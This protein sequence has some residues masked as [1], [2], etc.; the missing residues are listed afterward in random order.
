M[1]INHHKCNSWVGTEGY[2]D[3]TGKQRMEEGHSKCITY[4]KAKKK[5]KKLDKHK[6]VVVFV[7]ACL[8]IF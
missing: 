5:V 2:I 1:V 4:M 6:L 3:V 8:L 7:S